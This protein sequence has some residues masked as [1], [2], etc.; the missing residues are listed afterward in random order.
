MNQAKETELLCDRMR[1]E[2][3]RFQAQ[4]AKTNV[5]A[6][7]HMIRPAVDSLARANMF[8]G[9]YE[10]LLEKKEELYSRREKVA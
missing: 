3:L 10:K 4:I 7:E 6:G 2:E 9:S 8:L 1:L 5:Y